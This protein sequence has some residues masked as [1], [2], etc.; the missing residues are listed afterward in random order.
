MKA[1]WNGKVVAES[2]DTV[3]VGGYHYFPIDSVDEEILVESPAKSVCPWKGV[4]SYYT[5]QVGGKSAHDAA[6]YYA[7]P[8]FLARKVKNRIAF[9]KGVRVEA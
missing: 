4:A 5:V 1:I 6:F 2:D 7:K 9:W 3:V 8:S